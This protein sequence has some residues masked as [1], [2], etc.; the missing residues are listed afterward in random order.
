MRF[1]TS[2]ALVFFVAVALIQVPVLAADAELDA[3]S[4]QSDTGP[5]VEA[6]RERRS[7]LPSIR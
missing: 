6:A 3:L 5:T 4:L 7:G 1:F 2:F